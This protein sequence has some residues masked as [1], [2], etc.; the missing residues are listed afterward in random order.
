MNEMDVLDALGGIDAGL[1][2]EAGKAKKKG[3][4]LLYALA[5]CFIAA[6]AAAAVLGALLGGGSKGIVTPA[7]ENVIAGDRKVVYPYFKYEGRIYEGYE[8]YES[9]AE[10]DRFR[11]ESAAQI[12]FFNADGPLDPESLPELSG[13]FEGEVY[14]V[15]GVSP[16]LMLC[17]QCAGELYVFTAGSERRLYKGSEVFGDELHLKENAVGVSF[18]SQR[19]FNAKKHEVYAL[20]GYESEFGDF[21]DALYEGE[22]VY[23]DRIDP[24]SY[25]W[26]NIYI[27][28]ADGFKAHLVW[29][30]GGC[31]GL[32]G[33]RK[34]LVKL[35]E[36]KASAFIDLLEANAPDR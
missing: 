10:F 7:S 17:A 14:A 11:G 19:S 13:S 33:I 12:A 2:E 27:D 30:R 8:K 22:W 9:F 26:W 21:L 35:D 3:S 24:S 20:E 36:G 4:V 16:K 18:E 15:K 29:Y 1:V 28:L 31:V 25:R 6:I 23:E 5:A 32:F 34:A